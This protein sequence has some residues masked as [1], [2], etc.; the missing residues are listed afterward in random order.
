MVKGILAR[1][2]G[3]FQTLCLLRLGKCL[4]Q[5]FREG[6]LI[7]LLDGVIRRRII[8]LAMILALRKTTRTCFPFGSMPQGDLRQGA[9][10]V[11]L[12]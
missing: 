10:F 8:C 12:E 9:F 5:S 1:F 2:Y 3:M 11:T 4:L 7:Y 6:H